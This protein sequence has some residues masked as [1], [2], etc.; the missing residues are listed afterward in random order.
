MQTRKIL[1]TWGAV[2]GMALAAC[3][4]T[5]APNATLNDT[6]WLLVDLDSQTV[7]SDTPVTISFENG[8]I[9]GTDGCNRYGASYTLKGSKLSVDKNI[10]ATMM[11][12]PE[13][14]MQQASAYVT[15]LRQAA[16]FK[17]EGQQLTLLDASGKM[18]ASFTKESRE[19]D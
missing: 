18:L 7:L 9:S 8:E 19:S 4:T 2:V 6:S 11:A 12:C 10:A 16:A 13:P 14:I 5:N 1:I 17:I 15:A 3:A